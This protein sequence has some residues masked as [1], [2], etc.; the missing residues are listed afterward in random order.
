M[1]CW[2]CA[3]IPAYL[4]SHPFEHVDNDSEHIQRLERMVVV[5]Y[6]RTSSLSSA[7]DARS[8]QLRIAD[9][10]IIYYIY[11]VRAIFVLITRKE[12]GA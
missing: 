5:L 9:I 12:G 4:A 11:I 3:L 6:D 1:T 2:L 7:N 8:V 10:Y